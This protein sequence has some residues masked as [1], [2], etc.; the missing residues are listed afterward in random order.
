ME[1]L[2]FV[3]AVVFGFCFA[4]WIPYKLM[5]MFLAPRLERM[6]H[7]A[8]G[9]FWTAILGL[10]L[11]IGVF[12]I[13]AGIGYWFSPDWQAY[14]ARSSAQAEATAAAKRQIRNICDAAAARNEPPPRRECVDLL[15]DDGSTNPAERVRGH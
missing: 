6:S 13:L 2:L 7:E 5:A 1:G 3:W 14:M 9:R 15:D 11:A 8:Q 12:I 4:C 10:I